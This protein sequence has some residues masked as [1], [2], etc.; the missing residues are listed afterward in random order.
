MFRTMRAF[1]I[2][3]N[4]M[5]FFKHNNNKFGRAC[6][7]F[8]SHQDWDEGESLRGQEV[9]PYRLTKETTL[10]RADFTLQ[11]LKFVTAEKETKMLILFFLSIFCQ[12]LSQRF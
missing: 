9:E 12:L 11:L 5:I 2:R 8:G 4:T 3:V 1:K 7:Y 6:S 10:E